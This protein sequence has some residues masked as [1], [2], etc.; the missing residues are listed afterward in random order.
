MRV[1]ADAAVAEKKS[2][3]GRNLPAAIA[4]GVVLGGGLL[5]ILLFAPLALI[6]VMAVAVAIGT[7]EV[8]RRLR[9]AEVHVPRIPLFVGGQVIIWTSWTSGIDGVA[10]AFTGSAVLIIIWRLFLQGLKNPPKNWLRDSATSIF[11]LVWVPL[12]GAFASLLVQQDN[13]G[14]RVM[15]A[16]ICVVCNDVGGYAA[17][18]MFGKHPMVPAISPKKSWE[19]FAGSL[20]AGIIGGTLSVWLLL[21]GPLYAGAI[22]GVVLVFVATL[23]D[24]IESQFKRDLGIKDMGTMLPGHGGA[25]DRLDSILPSAFVAWV[26][27]TPLVA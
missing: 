13:G 22:L 19:G 2:R 8:I 7:F 14:F 24:L 3:A 27:L 15:C 5:V 18:V 26:I 17:G 9:E 23:G 4:V 1:A 12:L 20:S 25:M 6:P 16:V 10:A 11:V 21:D